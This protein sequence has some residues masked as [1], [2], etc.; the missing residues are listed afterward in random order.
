[1]G[2]LL[3]NWVWI[4]LLVIT[5]FNIIHRGVICKLIGRL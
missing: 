4:Y 3:F 1:M 5:I 2:R